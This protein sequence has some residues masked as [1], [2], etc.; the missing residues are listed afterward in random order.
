MTDKN[1]EP[2]CQDDLMLSNLKIKER[3]ETLCCSYGAKKLENIYMRKI[4]SR[5]F[6]IEN[7]KANSDCWKLDL[8]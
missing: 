5:R 2:K 1:L 6:L 7:S 3:R 4:N 8:L